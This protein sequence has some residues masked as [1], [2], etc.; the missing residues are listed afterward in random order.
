VVRQLPFEAISDRDQR[1]VFEPFAGHAPFLTAALGRLRALLPSSV[2]VDERHEYLVR[3]LSGI[4]VDSFACEIAWHSLILADYPNPNGWRIEVANA[5]TSP[6]FQEFLIG[7]N[8]VLCNPP[9]GQFTDQERAQYS[10]LQTAHKA[11]E[12]LLRVLETPPLML[13]F[14]LP[15]SFTDGRSYRAARKRLADVYGTISL[16]ALPDIA[17]RFSE[18]ET[19]VLL[20]YDRAAT[21]R[22]WHRAFIAK[23]DYDQFWRTGRPTWED[24]EHVDT[25]VG[26]EPQLW[27]EPLARNLKEQL[28]EL[29]LLGQVA[30]IHR[31]IEYIGFV[32]DHISTSPKQGFVQGLQNVEDGLEPYIIRR[33]QYLQVDPA[34]MRWKAYLLPWQEKKV[35]VNA[36]RI[37]RGPW[38]MVAAIDELGLVCS[39][40][41]HGIWPNDDTPLE[42]ITAVLNGP[43]ANVLLSASETTRDNLIRDLKAIPLPQ[44]SAH[45]IALVRELVYAYRSLLDRR[46]DQAEKWFDDLHNDLMVQIDTI[47]L[48]GYALPDWLEAKLMDFIG[49]AQRPHSSL[50]FVEQLR[51]RHGQLVDKKF[52]EG[53]SNVETQELNHIKRL[54]DAAEASYYAPIL[55]ALAV[56]HATISAV[57]SAE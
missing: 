33:W 45:D 18:A 24:V 39:Q 22:K 31:G 17:F 36:A 42:L 23:P 8:V 16:I 14:V 54:L 15:R 52:T 7:A 10:N 44:L 51:Y 3:M 48:S 53:L 34:V 2:G 49:S 9:F 57:P 4:E 6:K 41:F 46:S 11:V 37:G 35:V 38:R 28:K 21:E 43:V 55:E 19:V 30:E 5:F 29:A 40:R 25:P 47:V 13:G 50:S 27:K 1:T 12:V 20:A 56:A 32:E 26:P